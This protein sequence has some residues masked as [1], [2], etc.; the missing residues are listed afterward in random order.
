MEITGV[1][2]D[3]EETNHPGLVGAALGV[4]D[5]VRQ[6]CVVVHSASN[7][8]YRAARQHRP[9]S[10]PPSINLL[11]FGDGN[12]LTLAALEQGRL[13]MQSDS[14]VSM[15]KVSGEFQPSKHCSTRRERTIRSF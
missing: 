13:A 12:Q 2:E 8:L 3:R 10:A 11:E 1:L 6:Q 15:C 9:L 4:M 14:N 5:L 7:S